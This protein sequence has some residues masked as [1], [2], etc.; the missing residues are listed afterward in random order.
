MEE[1]NTNQGNE[2]KKEDKHICFENHCWKKC[3]AMLCAAFLGGFLAF[4]FV[5]DQMMHR[6]QKHPFNPQRFEKRMFDDVERMYKQDMKAFDDSFNFPKKMKKLKHHNMMIPAFMLDSVKIK[7]E[8]ENNVFKIIIDLKSFQDDEN[9][10]NYNV[11]GRKL[12]VFGSSEI[13]DKDYQHDVSFSQDFI[14]PENAEIMNIEKEKEG[15]NLI[16][17]I[18]VKE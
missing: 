1:N 6:Y 16:I 2:I 18:P 10:V 8:F 11:E 7:T 5:A 4:Y 14:L 3:L 17:S 15:H 13:K 9:K 12:T